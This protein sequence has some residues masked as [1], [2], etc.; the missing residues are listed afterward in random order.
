MPVTVGSERLVNTVTDGAQRPGDVAIGIRTGA[1]WIDDSSGSGV[2][3]LRVF[4]R[5][6]SPVV[7]EVVV[8]AATDVAVASIIG[9]FVVV[10]AVQVGPQQVDIVAQTYNGEGGAFGPAL[11][12]D[13]TDVRNTPIL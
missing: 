10:R 1:V 6:G 3:K 9:G 7:G 8:G 5:D 12:L 4:E 13:T 2:A 11:T